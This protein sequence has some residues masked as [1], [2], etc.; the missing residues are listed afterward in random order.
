MCVLEEIKWI[1]CLKKIV[2]ENKV[3]MKHN[4]CALFS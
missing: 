3:N 2:I 4:V 1:K